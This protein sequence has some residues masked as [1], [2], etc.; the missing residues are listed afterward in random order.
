MLPTTTAMA[1]SIWSWAT[2]RSAAGRCPGSRCGKTCTINNAPGGS[3]ESHRAAQV[4]P[5]AVNMVRRHRT[6]ASAS[7]TD[8][9]GADVS[10]VA[11]VAVRGASPCVPRS[12]GP[13]ARRGLDR[14]R[15]PSASTR[16]RRRQTPR[17]K[18]TPRRG[19]LRDRQATSCRREMGRGA[20]VHFSLLLGPAGRLMPP[21]FVHGR[22]GRAADERFC[23][24]RSKGPVRVP[25]GVVRRGSD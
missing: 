21:Y 12:R 18:R 16:W 2:S 8:L 1:T 7:E 24:G 5:P 14:P 10:A 15:L 13:Q 19:G 11:R 9:D 17:E 6:P 22:R 23:V 25:A 20:I 4:G 3:G